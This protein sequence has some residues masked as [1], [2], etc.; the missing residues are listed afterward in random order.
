MDVRVFGSSTD[1]PLSMRPTEVSDV[2]LENAFDPI[3]VMPSG[4]TIRVKLCSE[5][6]R[7]LRFFGYL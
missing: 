5:R 7:I 6:K 1:A 2:H 4:T 3:D